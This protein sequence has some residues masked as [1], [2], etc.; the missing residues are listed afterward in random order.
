MY[1]DLHQ[2]IEDIRS[3]WHTI[4]QHY[5]YARSR[6]FYREDFINMLLFNRSNQNLPK[7]NFINYNLAFSYYSKSRKQLK[8]KFLGEEKT[9]EVPYEELISFMD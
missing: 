5:Q 6:Y 4:E 3:N 2:L 7:S 8:L 1:A 9:L